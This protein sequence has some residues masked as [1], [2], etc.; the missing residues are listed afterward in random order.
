MR[1]RNLLVLRSKQGSTLLSESLG[2]WLRLSIVWRAMQTGE[3]I[4]F[5]F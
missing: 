3:M 1:M 2:R 4:I 5:L